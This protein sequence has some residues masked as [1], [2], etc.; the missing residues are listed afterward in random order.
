MTN[1]IIFDSET[2]NCFEKLRLSKNHIE[3][4]VWE[5]MRILEGQ[6]QNITYKNLIEQKDNYIKTTNLCPKNPQKEQ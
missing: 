1:R 3:M 2:A 6:N 4:D 5:A